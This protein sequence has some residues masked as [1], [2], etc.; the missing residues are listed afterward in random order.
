MSCPKECEEDRERMRED[1]KQLRQ[2][3]MPIWI[4]TLL[5][6]SIVSLFG[7]VAGSWAYAAKTYASKEELAQTKQDI[8]DEI[9][10]GY[11]EILVKLDSMKGK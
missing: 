4:R 11:K 10:S 5:I 1:I 6:A 7:M 3:S 8:K 2:E 9:R